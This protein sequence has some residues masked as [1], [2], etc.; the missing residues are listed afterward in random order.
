MAILRSAPHLGIVGHGENKFTPRTKRL[1]FQAI[2]LAMA[3]YNA[4]CIVSGR[5]PLGGIDIWAEQ[6]AIDLGLA[7]IIHAPR[8]R[9]WSGLGGY[10]DRNL[11]IARDSDLVLCIV[12]RELPPDYDGMRFP[13]CYHCGRRN[14]PHVKSGGC[15]TA[16][17]AKRRAWRI[18][19]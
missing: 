6:M 17:K 13:K 1:A 15:W 14:P 4:E 8:I 5:S 7:T 11:K 12:V 2:L 9:R 18:I 10:R 16:W 3:K 19:E